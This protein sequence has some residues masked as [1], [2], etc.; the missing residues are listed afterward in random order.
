[1]ESLRFS[2]FR[3]G[4]S[5]FAVWGCLVAAL[6]I[7]LT[8]SWY[9]LPLVTDDALISYRYSERFLHGQ[10]LTWNDGE[11]VE[12]YSNLLWVLLVAA[13]GLIQPNLILV[14]W[15]LGLMANAAV[16]VAIVWAF[17]RSS[18]AS[19]LPVAGGLLMLSL[20]GSFAIWGVG[21]LETALVEALLAWA[22]ATTYRMS[23]NR[24]GWVCP[25]LLLGLLS[26]TRPDGILF[27]M[28]IAIAVVLRDG[29]SRAAVQ[30]ALNLLI[31]P[32]AFMGAQ[33]GFRLAYYGSFVANTA[34]AKLAFTLDR[35]W[36]GC[37]YVA[38]GMVVN[39]I[40]LTI[41]LAAIVLLWRSQRWQVLRQIAVFLVP[42]LVWLA[43]V[44]IIG[45]D[46]FPF[47]R[48]WM[49]ALVC[50][51]F[52]LSSLLA[53][54]P[55]IRPRRFAVVLV[56]AS[57]LD[58]ALQMNVDS[59]TGSI[60]APPQ[61]GPL[62]SIGRKM[63]SDM[64]KNPIHM[65]E[66]AMG[67]CIAVGQFLHNAFGEE[68]PLV[69]VNTAGCLPYASRL[70]SLDM[71]GL[72]DSH[73]A[74]HRPIDM[75]KGLLAHELGDGAYVLSRKPDL[76]AFCGFIAGGEPC[77][78]SEREMVGMP[79]FQRYYR[80]VFFRAGSVD[81]S[82]WTRIEDGRLGIIRTADTIYI[83]GFLLA[84]TPGVR[85]VLGTAGK[86]AAALEDGDAVVERVYF[87][88]GTWEVS[89]E[90]DASNHLQLATSPSSES[91]ALRSGALRIASYGTALSL[92]VFG[93]H[94]LVYS[95]TAKRLAE[96]SSYRPASDER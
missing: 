58:L 57:V 40:P 17:G 1:M 33:I 39:S 91:T 42:G 60:G 32:F 4:I 23:A 14:G 30:R 3:R 44:G 65:F 71:L 49:P 87:P 85:G 66:R 92:R 81:A 38:Q 69:A 94:G 10:G 89:L 93:G 47:H 79:D 72:T 7:S 61:F 56:V 34:Y 12:G 70:P 46:V 67:R 68:Q 26:I 25:G 31:L 62:L 11:F 64:D 22:L 82:L 19:L 95:I 78:R 54:L 45:G 73:I 80:L 20:S 24:W 88:V 16:L 83:P 84:T 53:A 86:P 27:G 41:M 18:S 36:L 55:A 6:A 5:P 75:G 35:V 8:Y 90:T 77:F 29:F 51:A 52:T 48:H 96:Y 50:F 37:L 28:S 76:I 9:Y 2:S 59:P 43:Y 63:D 21:G 13:G 15:V 74:H